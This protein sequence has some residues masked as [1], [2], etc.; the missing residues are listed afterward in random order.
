[1][2]TNNRQDTSN[3]SQDLTAAELS[4]QLKKLQEA[5]AALQE[6]LQAKEAEER[7]IFIQRMSDEF[8]ALVNSKFTASDLVPGLRVSF[9]AGEPVEGGKVPIVAKC[10][11]VASAI[12]RAPSRRSS[13]Q[14]PKMSA[15]GT[16]MRAVQDAYLAGRR[17]VSTIAKEQGIASSTAWVAVKNL[18][19]D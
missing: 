12:H 13:N 18:G 10:S 2:A 7:A 4:A 9:E 3:E 15:P 19:L 6:K 1:V 8:T 16:A 17:D 5:Q 14:G 11:I